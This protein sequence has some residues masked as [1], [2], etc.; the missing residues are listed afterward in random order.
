MVPL[1]YL[2]DLLHTY[3]VSSILQLNRIGGV[4][5]IVFATSGE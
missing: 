5:A 2:Q 1:F 3:L 4:K